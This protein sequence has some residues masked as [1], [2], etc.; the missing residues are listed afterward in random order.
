[1]SIDWPSVFMGF[2]LSLVA[3]YYFYKKGD[4]KKELLILYK[5]D[6][7][8]FKNHPSIT[9][10]FDDH[11]VKS[12]TMTRLLIINIG[13]KAITEEDINY[14]LNI[15]LI[16]K[17]KLLSSEIIS[18]SKNIVAK[19]KSSKSNIIIE[20]SYLNKEN[21]IL[22]DVIHEGTIE[23]EDEFI[24]ETDHIIDGDVPITYK[25]DG[26][27]FQYNKAKGE[28]TAM[29]GSLL[30]GSFM[31]FAT[32]KLSYQEYI[33]NNLFTLE[34]MLPLI[35]IAIIA[36]A[37]LRTSWIEGRTIKK[38]IRTIKVFKSIPNLIFDKFNRTPN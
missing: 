36:L 25:Y 31:I 34:K 24:I 35:I 30:V 26:S 17:A 8:Q 32:I 15:D 11:D 5:S 1:M 27:K 2:I 13:E 18:K 16:S 9:I 20:F 33:N 37:A 23:N 28:V 3:S 19:D 21:Y 29:V 10:L 6:L 14:K 22:L 38:N 7:L 4:K 12:I